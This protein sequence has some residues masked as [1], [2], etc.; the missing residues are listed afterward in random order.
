[1]HVVVAAGMVARRPRA[2]VHLGAGDDSPGMSPETASHHLHKSSS[3]LL[4]L[5]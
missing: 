5:T 4:G 2:I 1:M 3:W